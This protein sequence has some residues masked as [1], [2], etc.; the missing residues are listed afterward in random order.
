MMHGQALILDVSHRALLVDGALL[1]IEA[2]DDKRPLPLLVDAAR[3]QLGVELGMPLGYR[4]TSTDAWFVFVDPALTDQRMVPLREWA[5]RDPAWALYVEAMLGGWSPPTRELEVCYFGSTPEQAALLAHVIIKGHKRATTGW[6]AA[7]LHRGS[8]VPY[9]GMTTIVTDGFGIPLCAIQTLRVDHATFR[10]ATDEIA[11]AE[12][13]GDRSLAFWREGH[14]HYFER[15][16]A[17]FGLEFTD[18]AEMFYEYFDVLH[19]FG[20]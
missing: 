2:P 6:T 1:A 5:T 18:D 4:S 16:A 17:R 14:S 3:E 10:D 12:A 8:A 15:E 20:R 7:E 9:P 19:V 13:E 11:A